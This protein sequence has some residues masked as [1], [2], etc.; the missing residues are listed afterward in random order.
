MLLRAFERSDMRIS[1]RVFEGGDR[2]GRAIA[3]FA[4]LL[5]PLLLVAAGKADDGLLTIKQ[6][7]EA[8]TAPNRV[9]GAS[10]SA[11]DLPGRV[12]LVWNISEFVNPVAQ[13]VRNESELDEKAENGPFEKLRGQTKVLRSTAKG[14]MRDGRLL[15]IAVDAAPA[16]PELRRYRSEA[17]RRL[18]PAFSVYAVEAASQLFGPDGRFLTRVPSIVDL[19][20]GDRLTNALK[21][22]PDY[23]PGRI[24]L[25]RTE[26]HESVAKR[27]VEG[28]NIEAPLSALRKEALGSGAKADEARRMVE[29]VEAYLK[30]TCSEIEADLK[31]APSMAVGRIAMLAK[32]SPSTARR[33]YGAL[34]ALRRTSEVKQLGAVRTFLSAANAGKVGRGDMGRTADAMIQKLESM[35]KHANASIAAEAALLKTSLLAFSSEALEREQDGVRG[36]VRARKAAERKAAERSKDEGGAKSKRPTAASVI[37]ANAGAATIAPLM[38]ELSRIDDATCN[39]ENL[40]NTYVKYEQQ[41]GEKSVAAKALMAAIDG[42]RKS[43]F[44]DLVRIQ[45]EGKP[46]DLYERGN[47]ERL[48][49]VNYPSLQSTD[50]GRAALKMLR[51]SEIRRI[52]GI[53]DDIRHGHADREEGETGEAYAVAQT[54]YL[55][56]KLKALLKYRKTNS[57]YGR[58]CVAQLDALGF[59]EQAIN[60]QLSDLDDK[61][62]EQKIAARAAEKR[63]KDAEKAARRNRDD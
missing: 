4:S 60:K 11:A 42:T 16:D 7:G 10:L 26:F 9:Y 22:A 56:T 48:I 12:V 21:D 63:R 35:S 59:G 34:G 28:K 25:F 38:E 18:K 17:V 24:L 46:L 30:E 49:T 44:D 55:Q 20:E 36:Q 39:Y 6:V 31:S 33:Y 47:W 5:F 13:A 40:R 50:E 61:L 53:L 2:M 62:K 3:L 37:A 19:A 15:I 29:A 32:T 54:Q 27:F 51:D 58:L 45:K 23:V 52:Y 41:E 43:L 57:A 8:L 14:A 1:F